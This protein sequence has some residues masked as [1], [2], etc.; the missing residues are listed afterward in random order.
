[1]EDGSPALVTLF[2]PPERSARTF[3]YIPEG[4]YKGIDYGPNLVYGNNILNGYFASSSQDGV[5]TNVSARIRKLEPGAKAGMIIFD[6]QRAGQFISLPRI[7]HPAVQASIEKAIN[8]FML[9]MANKD[10]HKAFNIYSTRAK[11][12]TSLSIIRQMVDGS[13]FSLFNGYRSVQIKFVDIL[14]QPP[15]NPEGSQYP[16]ALVVG[17]LTYAGGHIGNFDATLENE[18]NEW[19]IFLLRI[20]QP[21]IKAGTR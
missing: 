13:N 8:E 16:I 6:D 17:V 21:F 3:L 15:T 1:M 2:S 19:K 7:E 9:A 12:Q 10:C 18:D 5:K 4:Q 11:S 14:P 20:N